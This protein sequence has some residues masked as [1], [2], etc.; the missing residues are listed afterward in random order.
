ITAIDGSSIK[1]E[2]EIV[3][4]RTKGHTEGHFKSKLEIKTGGNILYESSVQSWGDH[5]NI[6]NLNGQTL[7]AGEY[8]G[9]LT[10][11]SRSYE[12]P[13]QLVN[14]DLGIT[15]NDNY[16]IHPNEFTRGP[17]EG[18]TWDSQG[19]SAGCQIPNGHEENYNNLL[20]TLEQ[21]GFQMGEGY[22]VYT[23]TVPVTINDSENILTTTSG[24]EISERNFVE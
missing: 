16:Y 17:N 9:R 6:E 8:E 23:D 22:K 11:H 15:G 19:Y 4:A 7:I 10:G 24:E 13:I 2:T 18:V 14:E 1:S 21:T 12:N 5:P 3:I 20:G